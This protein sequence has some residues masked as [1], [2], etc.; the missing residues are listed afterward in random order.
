MLQLRIAIFRPQYEFHYLKV[1][2]K[3]KFVNLGKLSFSIRTTNS[4]L[5]DSNTFRE[6]IFIFLARRDQFFHRIFL[7]IPLLSSKQCWN[8]WKLTYS[9]PSLQLLKPS[10]K[11][12]WWRDPLML[13]LLFKC[14][15]MHLPCRLKYTESLLQYSKNYSFLTF[16]VI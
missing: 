10:D 8:H 15:L 6:F 16:R 3:C 5:L 13:W 2:K 1:C 14:N 12:A 4:T 11:N 7:L 9:F